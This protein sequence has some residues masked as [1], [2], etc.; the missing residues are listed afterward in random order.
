M[1]FYPHF[2][3]ESGAATIADVVKHI[4]HMLDLGGENCVGFGSDFDGIEC[5][6]EGLHNPADLPKL[7]AY[8]RES[9]IPE[10]TVEKISGR[11]LLAY[12]DRVFPRNGGQS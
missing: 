1:N 7:I 8:L 10:K 4:Q 9:G 5:K 6:P 2:L 11:N 12:F 3:S